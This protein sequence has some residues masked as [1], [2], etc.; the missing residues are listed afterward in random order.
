MYE[1]T[2]GPRRILMTSVA[3]VACLLLTRRLTTHVVCVVG[4]TFLTRKL[5]DA[6]AVCS[7]LE[8]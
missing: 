7:R 4:G 8:C 6:S 2:P 1:R 3:A 5:V